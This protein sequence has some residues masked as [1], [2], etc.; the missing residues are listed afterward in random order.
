MGPRRVDGVEV[1]A[2]TPYL[3]PPAS[4]GRFPCV[5]VETRDPPADTPHIKPHAQL[6]RCFLR[7]SAFEES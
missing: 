4:F 2:R 1:D 7:M 3:R 6:D 5:H